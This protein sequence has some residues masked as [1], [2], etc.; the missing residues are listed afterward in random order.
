MDVLSN[1]LSTFKVH[2]KVFHNGQICGAWQIDTSGSRKAVLHAVTHGECELQFS[3]GTH[4]ESTLKIGDV[5]LLP[6]DLKCRICSAKEVTTKLN[7]IESKPFNGGLQ[8]DSTGLVCAHMEFEHE[9]NNFLFDMLP[10]YI[11]IKGNEM[12]WKQNL[13]PIIDVLIFESVSENPGVQ[14]TLNRLVEMVIMIVIREFIEDESNLYGFAAALRD[15]KIYKVLDAIHNDPSKDWTIETLAE[16]SSMS[17]SAFIS[18]F[19]SLLNESPINYLTQWRMK[20][21]YKWFRD[22]NITIAEAT[23]RCGYET[24]AAFSKAFKRELGV[25]PGKVR[26]GEDPVAA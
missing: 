6:R 22:D 23:D 25:S 19:K 3:D 4:Y 7:D 16:I 12:P 21:A 26:A 15:P 5:I 10:E 9:A 8:N 17:R 13:K 20:A 24:E 1:V 2:A 18:K 14:E 11:V